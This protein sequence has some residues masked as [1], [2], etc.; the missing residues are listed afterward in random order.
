MMTKREK[1]D[2]VSKVC[3]L[4]DRYNQQRKIA[5]DSV[6]FNC[7]SNLGCVVSEIVDM[8]IESISIAIG[9]KHGYL[10]WFVYENYIGRGDNR[11]FI[12][13]DPFECKTV[14]NLIDIIEALSD[15]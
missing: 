12:E 1:I 13:S 5:Y 4:I 8:V 6:G 14:H 10:T 3:E 2:H 15:Q 7:E 11:V 9:D